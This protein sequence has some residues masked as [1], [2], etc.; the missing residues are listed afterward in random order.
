MGKNHSR[1]LDEIKCLDANKQSNIKTKI[2]I[3][4]P[5]LACWL[6]WLVLQNTPTASPQRGQTSPPSVLDMMLN[7]LNCK[8]PVMLEL[9]GMQS[10]LL[11]TSL[12]SPLWPSV[13]ALDRV[14]SIGQIGLNC[15]LM[16]N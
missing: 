5:S 16:L 8:A 7:N 11:L 1:T 4:F 2:I 9:W 13:V 3:P 6:I 15:V 14:L 10:T 12:P